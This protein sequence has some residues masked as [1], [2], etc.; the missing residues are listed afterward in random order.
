MAEGISSR[1]HRGVSA[2]P[3]DSAVRAVF[4][5]LGRG[6]TH[7]VKPESRVAQLFGSPVLLY[8]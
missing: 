8:S 6:I 3:S 5:V 7:V 1:A 4:P 2:R